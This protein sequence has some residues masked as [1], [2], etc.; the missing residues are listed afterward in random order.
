MCLP[1]LI[2][3]IETAMKDLTA[4]QTRLIQAEKLASMGQMAAGIAHE[5]NNPRG[6]C[7]MYSHLSKEEL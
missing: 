5:I 6:G 1:F 4:N 2:A 3:R 7:S